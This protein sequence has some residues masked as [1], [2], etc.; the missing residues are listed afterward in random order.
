MVG[1]FVPLCRSGYYPKLKKGEHFFRPSPDVANEWVKI[2]KRIRA[3]KIFDPGSEKHRICHLRFKE[4]AITKV[5]K[6]IIKG[7][8]GLLP[9]IKWT[10]QP[11]TLLTKFP[12]LPSSIQPKV[13]NP[14]RKLERPTSQPVKIKRLKR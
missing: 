7:E 10:L 4:I 6:F 14:R 11:G 9:R 5:D 3:D 13:N 12:M 8:E 1:C 2:V